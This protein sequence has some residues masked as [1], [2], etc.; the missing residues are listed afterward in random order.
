MLAEE[1]FLGITSFQFCFVL[2]QWL[3]FKRREYFYYLLHILTI[4]LYASLL[5]FSDGERYLHF[6][7]IS[8][9][10]LYVEKS[11]LLLT[12]GFYICFGQLFLNLPLLYPRINRY[13]KFT[14]VIIFSFCI[15][16]VLG[17]LFTSNFVFHAKMYTIIFT[18]VFISSLWVTGYFLLFEK[19]TF[20]RLLAMS[21]IWIAGGIFVSTLA[22]WHSND[23][24]MKDSKH[25]LF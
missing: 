23:I 14:E 24:L 2:F 25:M 4:I 18:L 12:Y 22:A 11:L 5:Y 17:L 15:V 13:V 21:G 3:V 1:L 8:I 9:N 10:I 19:Y 7:N 6:G 16:S 20:N